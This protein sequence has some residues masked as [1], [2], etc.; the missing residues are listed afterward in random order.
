MY[1][2][3][4]SVRFVLTLLFVTLLTT[5]VQARIN[6]NSNSNSEAQK[7]QTDEII[8]RFYNQNCRE[9]YQSDGVGG[10][11]QVSP[12]VDTNE[13]QK[14]QSNSTKQVNSPNEAGL[15]AKHRSEIIQ[16]CGISESATTKIVGMKD[17]NKPPDYILL[18]PWS[19]TWMITYRIDTGN[20]IFG[21]KQFQKKICVINKKT[22][23]VK[24]SSD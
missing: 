16:R 8:R 2:Y 19:P 4:F 11:K 5:N 23:S 20:I 3:F 12:P 6:T 17:D 22:G 14:Q 18:E 13:F 10:C 1:D 21:E 24:V 15:I 7:A 9:G